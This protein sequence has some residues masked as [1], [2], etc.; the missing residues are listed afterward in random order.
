MGEDM[1]SQAKVT[2]RGSLAF[3]LLALSVVL[4]IWLIVQVGD[5]SRES[6]FWVLEVLLAVYVVARLKLLSST[7]PGGLLTPVGIFF[8]FQF[9]VQVVIG[10]IS[11]PFYTSHFNAG[12]DYLYESMIVVALAAIALMIAVSF[13]GWY[14]LGARL[15]ELTLGKIPKFKLNIFVSVV[16]LIVS[17]LVYLYSMSIGVLGYSDSST[18]GNYANTASYAQYFIYI[19]DI[20]YIVLLISYYVKLNEPENIAARN[21]FVC[22]LLI[23]VTLALMSGMKAELFFIVICLAI[24][25]FIVK[26]KLPKWIIL[27]PVVVVVT[28]GVYDSY[29]AMLRSDGGSRME[30]MLDAF[31]GSD[32]DI[33]AT[34]TAMLAR[35]NITESL[36]A[37]L[38]YSNRTTLTSDDPTFLLDLIL[39]P[40]TTFLPRALFPWK[41]MSTYGL[42]VTQQV[43]GLGDSVYSSSYVTVEGFY[44][45]AG[46]ILLVFVGFLTLGFFLE[47][48]GGFLKSTRTN[49]IAAAIFLMLCY[50]VFLEASTPVDIVTP[51]VRG[52]LVFGLAS[53]LLVGW[54][55]QYRL[56]A[57]FRNNDEQLRVV[58]SR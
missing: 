42:W 6:A 9:G 4:A 26:R 44:Y 8:L 5:F 51:C 10:N 15:E 13:H 29:R 11:L 22:A 37:I 2:W 33:G 24:M 47:L 28:Y 55:Y 31:T 25:H 30:L 48:V 56:R 38:E 20:G 7:H 41:S 43:Y 12:W 3:D 49:P 32:L 36:S 14:K 39:L 19:S 52:M 53:Y 1:F 27:L 34:L 21:V 23:R 18:V 50:K 45:L 58:A 16:L 17:T 57:K 40:L 46:G 35:L 54:R